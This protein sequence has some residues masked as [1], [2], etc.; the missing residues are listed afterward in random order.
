MPTMPGPTELITWPALTSVEIGQLVERA[1]VAVVDVAVAADG[2]AREAHE[3]HRPGHPRRLQ[4]GGRW[5]RFLAWMDE[6]LMDASQRSIAGVVLV[7]TPNHGSP[8]A[9]PNNAD[10]VSAGL[11]GI[12]TGLGGFPIVGAANPNTRAAIEAQVAGIAPAGSPVWRF[13]VGAVCQILDAAI[14]DTPASEPDRCDVLRTARKWLTG[15]L[16]EKVFTAFD[17]LGP[18]GLDNPRTI[19]G[20]LATTPLTQTFHGAIVGGDTSARRSGPRRA[21]L[22]GALAGAPPRGPALVRDGRG[23]LRAHRHG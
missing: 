2:I 13:G 11:L 5:Q 16:E 21:K 17:D 6:Q 15:L 18:A 1:G 3:D 12:L 14:A 7:Q 19:L 8:L 22:P 9:N 23:F 10:N 20:R 4:P